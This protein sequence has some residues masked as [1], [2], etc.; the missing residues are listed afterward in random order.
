MGSRLNK[1]PYRA[2]W[3]PNGAKTQPTPKSASMRR[4]E[5]KKSH[6]RLHALKGTTR[7]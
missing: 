5:G 2:P 7:A 3:R 6:M 1:P 4:V